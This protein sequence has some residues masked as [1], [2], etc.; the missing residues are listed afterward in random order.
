MALNRHRLYRCGPAILRRGS[1]DP[2]EVRAL[3]CRDA[4]RLPAMPALRSRA[5]VRGRSPFVALFLAVVAEF[6][7]APPRSCPTWCSARPATTDGRGHIRRRCG[8][9]PDASQRRARRDRPVRYASTAK[10][11]TGTATAGRRLT[12]ISSTSARRRS[13]AGRSRNR[14]RARVFVEGGLGVHFLTQDPHQQQ[15]PVRH[16]LPVRRDRQRRRRL[17]RAESLRAQG[18]RAARLQWQHQLG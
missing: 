11:R 16:R 4:G 7:Q 6:R 8:L 18:L 1:R 12:N 5:A 17:R 10:S 2:L 14:P 9:V 3:A 13:S 15:P